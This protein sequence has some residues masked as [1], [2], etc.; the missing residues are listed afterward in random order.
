MKSLS[1]DPHEAS[2]L[3]EERPLE[4]GTASSALGY[5]NNLDPG[6]DRPQGVPL[7]VQSWTRC[8]ESKTSILF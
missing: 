6:R 2:V 7:A 3:G 5:G 8:V 1:R 4:A